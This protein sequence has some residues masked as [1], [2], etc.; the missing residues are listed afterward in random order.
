MSTR[1][2]KHFGQHFLHDRDILDRIVHAIRP[3]P[4]QTLVEIGPGAGAL[5]LPLLDLAGHLIAIELDRDLHQPLRERASGHGEL[6]LI[7]ANVLDVDFSTLATRA[8]APLR[9]VGNLPYY[10][11]SPI[12]FHCLAHRTAIGD[13]TFLLQ[14]EVVQRIVAEPGSK[15]YGRLSVMLQLACRTEAL[16]EVPPSAFTPPPKVDS[17]LVRLVPRPE[18]E[19]PDADPA[20]LGEI[21]R[22]AFGQRRKTLANALKRHLD[23]GQIQ[24]AGIDPRARAETLPPDAFVRLARA[25]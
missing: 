11:S 22:A 4:D 9:V 25:Q 12:L 5:T 18:S 16:L 13:M 14:K 24:A 17:A 19:Q 3:R 21:V 6:E 15:I 23:A 1:L 2:K 10:L 8:G 20:T 7:E